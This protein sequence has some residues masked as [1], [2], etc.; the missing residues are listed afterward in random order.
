MTAAV[1]A[2]SP[3]ASELPRHDGR[4]E[5]SADSRRRIL[6]AMVELIESGLAAPTAEMIAARA[7][8]SLRTVF[9]HFEE[10]ENLYLE[11]ASIVFER[12][13]PY[14]ESPIRTREW[15]AVLDQ[16]IDRRAEFFEEI[17][18]Y[19]TAIDVYRHRSQALASQHRRITMLSRDMLIATFPPQVV[20][21]TARF[22]LLCLLLSVESWQRLREQQGLSQNE[23]KELVR[24]GAHAIALGMALDS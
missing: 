3:R 24:Q 9:R 4:R 15:P 23:A 13:K 19:K 16:I 20:A 11:I 5:R 22:E 8:V 14:L 10:M 1:T 18:P 12:V 2:K 6:S 17:S 7:G 21:D